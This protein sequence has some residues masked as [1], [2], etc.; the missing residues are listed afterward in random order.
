MRCFRNKF[1]HHWHLLC[2]WE[3]AHH[4]YPTNSQSRPSSWAGAALTDPALLLQSQALPGCCTHCFCMRLR[5][6]F[7]LPEGGRRGRGES[8]T[9]LP[10]LWRLDLGQSLLGVCLQQVQVGDGWWWA[11]LRLLPFLFA[12]SLHLRRFGRFGGLGRLRGLGWLEL[13][14]GFHSFGSLFF[15][16]LLYGRGRRGDLDGRWSLLL[17]HRTDLLSWGVGTALCFAGFGGVLGWAQSTGAHTHLFDIHLHPLLHGEQTPKVPRD[18]MEG[19]LQHSQCDPGMK[20]PPRSHQWC[21][22]QQPPAPHPSSCRNSRGFREWIPHWAAPSCGTLT[23][24]VH[25]GWIKWT[26]CCLKCSPAPAKPPS[27]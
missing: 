25:T 27:I 21:C 14:G 23:R 15:R 24:P 7:S 16:D 5:E 3:A 26:A 4:E 18:G 17:V 2:F 8:R 9:H 10:L 12:F 1:C 11:L 13:F 20:I 22:A 6:G 19:D